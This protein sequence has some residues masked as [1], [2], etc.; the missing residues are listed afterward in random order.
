MDEDRREGEL[1]GA[2]QELEG[3]DVLVERGARGHEERVAVVAQALGA[4]E[5]KAL[6]QTHPLR[7]TA[8]LVEDEAAQTAVVLP[9]GEREG[10]VTAVALEARL[11][12]L[13]L[14]HT[15]GCAQR[16]LVLWSRCVAKKKVK[17]REHTQKKK[18][19][20]VKLFVRWVLFSSFFSFLSFFFFDCVPVQQ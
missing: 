15:G 7:R 4:A 9:V 13:P 20:K 1:R 17:R 12:L 16:H 10:L 5:A 2:R 19:G 3:H 18:R 11:I 14:G 8:R 6:G